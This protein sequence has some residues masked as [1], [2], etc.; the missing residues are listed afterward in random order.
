MKEKLKYIAGYLTITAALCALL[1][2]LLSASALTFN[3]IQWPV[4]LRVMLI[5]G[6][7]VLAIQ[8]YNHLSP[9][10]KQKDSPSQN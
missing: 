1:Y 4:Y 7:A 3:V 8:T 2:F 10:W 5:F 6:T 9:T